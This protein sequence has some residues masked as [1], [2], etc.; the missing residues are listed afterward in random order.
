MSLSNHEKF[1][2]REI[3]HLLRSVA[4]AHLIKNTNRFRIIAYENATDT[5][6]HLTRELK[7][8]WQEGKL[9]EVPGFGSAIASSIDEYFKKGYS[10]HFSTILKGIPD[11]VFDLM[12]VPSI[13][14]KKAYKLV[15]TFKLENKKTLFVDLKKLCLKGEIAK[16]P[17][18]G[19]K[20]QD[21]I[22][23]ALEIFENKTKVSQRMPLP[24]AHALAEEIISYLKK[25]PFV[26]RVDV[27]GSLRRMVA[28]I[29]DVD[30]AVACESKNTK[31]IID[32]FLKYPNKISVDNAGEKKASIIVSSSM[33]VDLRVQKEESYGAMLQYFTGS[34]THNIK[35]REYALK[36]GYSLSE[37]GIKKVKTNKILEFRTEEAFY[38]FLGLSY[39]P[40]EIRE[41]TSEI[42]L[43]EKDKLPKLVELNDIKGDF[44]IHSSY[45]LQ[46]SHD[47]GAN[48]YQQIL[49][50]AIKLG[51]SYIGF[52]EHNP[53]ISGLSKDQV[54][55][56]M[57]K[58]YDYIGKTL[59]KYKNKIDYYVGLEVD[60]LPSGDLALPKEAFDYV[61]YLLISVHSV[62]GMEKKQMT[63]RVLR[64]L[65]NPKVKILGHP[66]GRLFNKRDG[67]EM[68]WEQIF[69]LCKKKQIA[70]EIN[71]WPERLDLP[72]TL[73]Y[74]GIKYGLNCVINT[75]A[76]ANDQMDNMY[77]GIAVARRGWA[78]KSDIINTLDKRELKKWFGR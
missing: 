53:K 68:D 27:L 65:N 23:K 45:N 42:E 56:I 64:A 2:N 41:G 39:I 60:I 36:K 61:D 52:S 74:K 22:L 57:K 6:E 18:F 34:K 31:S 54:V 55:E 15:T 9:A 76:H 71:S 21:S 24:Y 10:K 14:P 78:V 3:A 50:K 72:D 17:T 67:F 20:S 59:D 43:A 12:R 26:K 44:H 8:I 40:A 77:Y 47:L 58:R 1:S 70:L 7:D 62:F 19:K 37:W 25:N 29:G 16:I 49:E 46:P 11:T 63:K 28:T 73:V 30:I 66:T 33:R 13:G 5:V 51:Y 4:A 75:D 35:L 48:S 32:H 38:N 69:E